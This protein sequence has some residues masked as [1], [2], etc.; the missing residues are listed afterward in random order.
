VQLRTEVELADAAH[1]RLCPS[2]EDARDTETG[3]PLVADGCS[4]PGPAWHAP[5]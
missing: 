4:I 5:D 1:S 2:A 3:L